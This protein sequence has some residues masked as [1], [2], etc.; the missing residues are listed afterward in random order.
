VFLQV[1]VVRDVGRPGA[2]VVC[3]LQCRGALGLV[4]DEDVG[5]VECLGRRQ[6]R[7]RVGGRPEFRFE[8]FEFRLQTLDLRR[9]VVALGA[10]LLEFRL[11]PLVLLGRRRQFVFQPVDFVLAVREFRPEVVDTRCGRLGL[12][13]GRLRAGGRVRGGVGPRVPAVGP[14]RGASL[15]GLWVDRPRVLPGCIR[16]RTLLD[17]R[18]VDGL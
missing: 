3:L 11:E 10:D 14:G 18:R 7:L 1:Q 17:G 4:S 9:E 2:A 15:P 12:A 6:P 16:A 13:V 8:L 5:P